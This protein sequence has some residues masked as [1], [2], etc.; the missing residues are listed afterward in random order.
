MSRKWGLKTILCKW[1]NVFCVCFLLHVECSRPQTPF[2]SRLKR[3]LVEA[4]PPWV[5]YTHCIYASKRPGSTENVLDSACAI[6]SCP[7]LKSI[8]TSPLL[9]HESNL[10]VAFQRW[11]QSRAQNGF[12]TD[13]TWACLSFSNI[14]EFIMYECWLISLEGRTRC[15]FLVSKYNY[16]A[17]LACHVV[18]R[19]L[20]AGVRWVS[21]TWPTTW[22]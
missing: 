10:G 7:P 2:Q 11:N 17:C 18:L 20:C 12:K 21:L 22:A 6:K 16:C 15:C 13:A 1:K 8:M 3:I 5:S 19:S 4:C 14:T 9:K